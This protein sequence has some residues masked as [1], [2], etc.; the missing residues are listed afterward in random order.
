MARGFPRAGVIGLDLNDKA[1]ELAGINAALA[2]PES[3]DVRFCR[4]HLFSSLP[5]LLPDG[6]EVDVI[7]ANPPYIASKNGGRRG[8]TG[9]TPM[10]ADGGASLGLEMSMS[11]VQEGIRFL[12]SGG[13]LLLYTGVTIVAA[14]PGHDPFLTWILAQGQYQLLDYRVCHPD[15]WPEEIGNGA[16]VDAA[17]IQV[18]GAALRKRIIKGEGA[19]G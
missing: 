2:L 16:Y 10:Y 15:M 6:V 1:L 4:S 19:R 12:A 3:S 13:I 8:D 17:R 9:P 11:I 5:G 18:V 7:V 14:S